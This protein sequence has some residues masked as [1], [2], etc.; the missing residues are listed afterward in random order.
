MKSS[1]PASLIPSQFDFQLLCARLAAGQV[2]F[3][4]FVWNS[5]VIAVLSVIGNVISCSLAAYAF[6]RL[7]FWGKNFFLCLGMLML[8][9]HVTPDPAIYPVPEAQAGENHAR[10]WSYRNSFAVDAFFIF[11]MVQFFRG[12]PRELGRGGDDG[13]LQP[14]AD[15][16]ADHA[17]AVAAGSR[18]RRDLL[19]H[20]DLGGLLRPADLS[21]RHQ[22]L[23]GAAQACAPSID[24]TGSLR[25]E[26]PVRHVRA[27]R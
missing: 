6:A 7:N 17:A 14:L 11:L 24:S 10:R 13:R 1:A 12:I 8:P 15:L 21:Q 16:L 4:S 5:V 2:T 19:L 25:L 20:L 22:H 9:Y 23:H 26:Q 3:G 27:S 18:D